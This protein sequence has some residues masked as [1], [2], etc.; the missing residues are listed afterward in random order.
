MKR[1]NKKDYYSDG[2]RFKYYIDLEKYVDYL[3]ERNK[4]LSNIEIK[5]DWIDRGMEDED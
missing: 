3:E 1:P 5:N 4:I 2:V